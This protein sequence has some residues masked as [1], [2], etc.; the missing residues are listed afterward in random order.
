[1]EPFFENV[2]NKVATA[3]AHWASRV[4]LVAVVLTPSDMFFEWIPLPKGQ[5]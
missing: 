5:S 2:F 4:N 3:A 1:L